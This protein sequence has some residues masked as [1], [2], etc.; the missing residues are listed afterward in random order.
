MP[1][2]PISYSSPTLLSYIAALFSNIEISAVQRS[3]VILSSQLLNADAAILL[4]ADAT[5]QTNLV[6]AILATTDLPEGFID[7]L[8]APIHP[9]TRAAYTQSAMV[10][11]A[12][13]FRI[14]V[15][16]DVLDTSTSATAFDRQIYVD[17]GYRSFIVAPILGKS[18][19]LVV[20]VLY[21]S[22]TKTLT[23]PELSGFAT[24]C[25]EAGIAIENA[26]KYAAVAAAAAT[27]MAKSSAAAK[28]KEAVDLSS[29]KADEVVQQLKQFEALANIGMLAASVSHEV[30]NSLDGIKNYLYLISSETSADHPHKEYLKLVEAELDRTGKIIRQLL[31]LYKPTKTPMQEVNLNEIIEQTL[32]LLGKPLRQKQYT[33]TLNLE[34]TLPVIKGVPDQ[35]KQVFLNLFFNAIQAMPTGGELKI[36]SRLAPDVPN[37]VE[38]LVADTGVGIPEE[39]LEKIFEPFYTTKPGGTG[40]GLAVC[41]QIIQDHQGEIMLESKL[42][43]GTT[44]H[45]HLPLWAKVEKENEPPLF[46]SPPPPQGKLNE[47][48]FLP[49]ENT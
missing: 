44:L 19:L 45:I 4:D 5:D 49:K 23:K 48:V 3:L 2:E 14:S 28:R 39:K 12:K 8:T 20:L 40:L 30:N 15:V 37:R 18:E 29:L 17:Y 41:R 24:F 16:S 43:L 34:K 38:V 47:L 33:V 7:Q 1:G 32:L 22:T 31:D 11:I 13:G 6:P 42:N 9:G 35:L 10:K 27:A 21:F 46:R 36:T 26:R 25:R